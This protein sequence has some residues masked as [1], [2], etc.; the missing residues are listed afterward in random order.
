[1]G[2]GSGQ[3]MEIV[4]IGPTLQINGKYNWKNQSER[5]VFLG[6]K[7]HTGDIRVWFQFALVEKPNSV[8]CEV[9]ESDLEHFESSTDEKELT[10]S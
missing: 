6:T 7:R 8:W 5:L 1:M 2:T 10:Y 3:F 9:L 4:M